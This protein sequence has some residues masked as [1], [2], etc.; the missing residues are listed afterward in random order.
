MNDTGIV[1]LPY[2]AGHLAITVL[3]R[4]SRASTAERERVVAEISR[5][6]FDY[7]IFDKGLQR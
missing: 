6:A 4:D 1:Y 7:F 5:Y 3:M 2:D